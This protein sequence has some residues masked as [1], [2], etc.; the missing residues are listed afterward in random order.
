MPAAPPLLVYVLPEIVV[1]VS[2]KIAVPPRPAPLLMV[3]VDGVLFPEIVLL[4]T[5]I[6]SGLDV[7]PCTALLSIALPAF[8]E[9]VLLLIVIEAGLLAALDGAPFMTPPPVFPEIVVLLIT[10]T[11][12]TFLIPAPARALLTT[13]SVIVSVP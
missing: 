12:L 10:T 11:P 4:L 9:I 8:P 3:P 7:G 13:Q 2:V 1:F 6:V 5:T